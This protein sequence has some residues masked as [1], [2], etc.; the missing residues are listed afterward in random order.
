LTY[1]KHTQAVE[2]VE[3]TNQEKKFPV[4]VFSHGLMGMRTTYSTLCGDLAS[5]GMI[6][7][8]IEHRDGSA[9]RASINNYSGSVEYERITNESDFPSKAEFD[10]YLY[11]I[12][13][14]QLSK[15][16][17]QEI[18]STIDILTQLNNGEFKPFSN[19]MSKSASIES[20]FK[21]KLNFTKSLLIG[22]SF[23]SATALEYLQNQSSS[24]K[25]SF[26]LGVVLDPWMFPF[27]ADKPIDV[28]ILSCNSESFHWRRNFDS[29][30]YQF[31]EF[32]NEGTFS[33]IKHTAHQDFSDIPSFFE[34]LSKKIGLGGEGNPLNRFNHVRSC[35]FQFLGRENFVNQ[36]QVIDGYFDEICK[37]R[38]DDVVVR[39][40]AFKYLDDLLEERAKQKAKL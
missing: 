16:R 36:V 5:N 23:G 29:M 37:G 28:P 14:R 7:A 33:V 34:L 19:S 24:N 27:K 4:A 2:N 26:G 31:D 22:H 30:K 8:S 12:R 6:V 11:S 1:F 21:D 13:N 35:V 20:S 39:D 10:K 25:F 40:V 3:I 15:T 38:D 17:I 18:H 32:L 9:S